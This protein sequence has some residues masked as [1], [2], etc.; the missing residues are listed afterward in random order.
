VKG[1]RAILIVTDNEGVNYESTDAEVVRAMF[2]ADTV[3]NAIVVRKGPRPPAA[4]ATGYTNPNSALP[5][6]YNMSRQTGGAA[7]DGI[8]KISDVFQRLVESIRSRYFLQY[9]APPAEL[10]GKFRRIRVEL[11][12][13]ARGRHPDVVIHAREGYYASDSH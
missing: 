6:V 4:R 3:L 1:R 9:S 7:M 10:A 8:G 5:D 11:S 2:A 13:E 12:P